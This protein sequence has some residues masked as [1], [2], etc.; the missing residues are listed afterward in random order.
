MTANYAFEADTVRLRTV[1]CYRR[2]PRGS[3]RRYCD[4]AEDRF[5][6]V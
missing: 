5:A 1:S 2:C 3:T 4:R 6:T